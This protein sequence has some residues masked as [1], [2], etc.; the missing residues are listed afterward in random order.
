MVLITH[1]TIR[2]VDGSFRLEGRREE[3]RR[4]KKTE[5]EGGRVRRRVS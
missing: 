4:E 1:L 3:T 2:D 5:E